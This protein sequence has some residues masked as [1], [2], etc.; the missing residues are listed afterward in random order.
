M[1]NYK[2]LKDTEA[3]VREI[4]LSHPDWNARQIY[5]R[6]LIL[7]G[8]TNKAVTLNAVQKHVHVVR[9]RYQKIQDTGNDLPWN[10]DKTLDLPAE[11]IAAIIKYKN[12]TY[13]CI[14]MPPSLSDQDSK[15]FVTHEGKRLTAIPRR[16]TVREARWVARLYAVKS[17]KKASVLRYA[18]VV[19]SL[20]ERLAELSGEPPDTSE[21][22]EI[23]ASKN[24]EDALSHYFRRIPHETWL[25]L[26][27][28]VA[29]SQRI[30]QK[31]G[32]K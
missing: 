13:Q 1:N 15:Y 26:I 5:D 4:F 8:D 3:L 30:Q 22:D 23:I 21:A 25:E 12:E 14:V 32:E 10:L 29:D 19:Y 18:V 20:L 6:Y 27:S 7:V 9:K 17:L 31:E 2:R 24:V 11:A 16:L 28:D